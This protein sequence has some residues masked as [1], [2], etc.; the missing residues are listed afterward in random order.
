[1]DH[2][3]V[4]RIHAVRA[5]SVEEAVAQHQPVDAGRR[6]H[7]ALQVDDPGQH[8]VIRDVRQIEEWVA[9]VVRLA[10]RGVQPRTALRNHPGRP[11]RQGSRPSGYACRPGEGA[12]SHE[13]VRRRN[14][15]RGPSADGSR[16]AGAAS[17]TAALSASASSASTT[18]ACAPCERNQAAR[19]AERVVPV[20]T[21]PASMS[22][23]TSC[24]PIAPAAP[25]TKTRIGLSRV[26]RRHGKARSRR[27]SG[28]VMCD[29]VPHAGCP[30]SRLMRLSRVHGIPRTSH[31][32]L[33]FREHPKGYSEGQIERS[34]HRKWQ[35][36]REQ[37][38]VA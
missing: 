20:T 30:M 16:P 4:T 10:A 27:G 9:L 25:A 5:R 13:A 12:R 34:E 37:V 23:G 7:D 15:P 6:G 21:W 35:G 24:R 17:R 3:T 36:G 32:G 38:D 31:S 28:P 22:I 26:Q 8:G 33:S 1:M 14:P 19:S 11:R 18:T 2:G 29:F